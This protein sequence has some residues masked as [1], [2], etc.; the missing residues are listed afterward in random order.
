MAAIALRIPLGDKWLHTGTLG[1]LL[2]SI[3]NPSPV[4]DVLRPVVPQGDAKRNGQTRRSTRESTYL[5]KKSQPTSYIHLR[6]LKTSS[7]TNLCAIRRAK[8]HA[9]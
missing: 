1:D 7:A 5:G 3:E 4:L 8:A 2:N 9:S 6:W